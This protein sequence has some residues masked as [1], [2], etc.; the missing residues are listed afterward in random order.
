MSSR[1]SEKIM[2][3]FNQMHKRPTRLQALVPVI[4]T[5]G[6]LLLAS[7]TL[8]TSMHVPLLIGAASAVIIAM[9]LGYHFHEIQEMMV[10]GVSGILPVIFILILVGALMGIWIASGIVPAMVYYGLKL[11]TPASFLPLAFILCAVVSLS[12]GTAFGTTSTIGIAMIGIGQ[13]L[14]LPLPLVAGAVVSGVYFGDRLSPLG[15]ALNLASAVTQ[16]DVYAT[17]HHL[18]S[19]T[20]AP[21]V[22]S[23]AFYAYAGSQVRSVLPAEATNHVLQELAARFHLTPWLL[24]PPAL[25]IL[26]AGLRVPAIP[27]LALGTLLGAIV[28][29]VWQKASLTVIFTALHNGF[30]SESSDP[31]LNQLLSRGGITSMA[32][33]LTLLIIAMAFSGI[34]E[35]TGVLDTLLGGTLSRL[36]TIPSLVTG[37]A[38]VGT[39]VAMV[40]ANQSLPIIVMGRAFLMRYKEL[41]LHPK[42][43][44]RCLLDSTGILCP[45][46]PW[47]LNGLFMASMLGV[48]VSSYTPYAVFC[49]LL[50][51]TT[52]AFAW[53]GIGMTKLDPPPVTTQ[54]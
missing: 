10:Q 4:I 51:L 14:G 28:A 19:T 25:V 32:D 20:V 53:F 38:V 40:S 24:L 16:S 39:L 50:P 43:L 21:F 49:W 45:L 31:V 23:L 54:G 27:S 13:A 26:L 2:G 5:S 6:L 29:G 36:R 52:L 7:T 37:T 11:I 33:V 18:F 34:L 42:N 22:L 41:N 3:G 48:S 47:N 17:M 8:H 46:I 1:V 35:K 44:A 12:I 15:S 9:T 30:I